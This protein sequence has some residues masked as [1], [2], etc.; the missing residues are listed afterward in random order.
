MRA[1][2]LLALPLLALLALASCSPDDA[3]SDALLED[4]LELDAEKADS[5]SST[6]IYFLVRPDYRKCMYPLCGGSFV[7]RAN[8]ATVKCGDGKWASEC[9][10]AE[11]ELAKLKLGSDL[12]DAVRSGLAEERGVLRGTIAK[13]TISGKSVDR[14]IARE[15][16]LAPASGPLPAQDSFYRGSPSGIVCVKAPCPTI[17]VAKLNS[18]IAAN[19]AEPDLGS[20]PGTP[21]EVAEAAFELAHRSLVVVGHPAGPTLELSQVYRRILAP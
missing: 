1:G 6:S 9:Y 13:T 11:I 12:E 18:T 17:H 10:V 2:H 16:W 21:A 15:A 8:R 5:Y 14:L 7:R 20:V 19:I 4:D 3:F